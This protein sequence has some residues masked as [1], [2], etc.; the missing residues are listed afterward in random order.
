MFKKI[1][2]Y[3]FPILTAIMLL[4]FNTS[5][6]LRS[7]VVSTTEP[8]SSNDLK[9]ENI[10][11]QRHINVLEGRI[12]LLTDAL[13]ELG[14]TTPEQSVNLWAKGIQTRNGYLQYSVLCEE[15]KNEFK[16]ELSKAQ[17]T[18]WVTGG[19]S[20]WVSNYNIVGKEKVNPLTYRFT[21]HFNWATSM[22]PMDSTESTITIT[23]RN[24]KWCVSNIQW[25]DN[26]KERVF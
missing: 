22:G 25:G 18:S 7:K 5:H 12:S 11:L 9:E 26:M 8:C 3:T 20:P 14:A 23:Y 13:D 4:G 24:N 17:R 10:Q 16:K 1:C 19:S 15:M 6:S 2:I 21:I